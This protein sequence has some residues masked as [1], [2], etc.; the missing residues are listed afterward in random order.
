MWKPRRAGSFAL[1]ALSQ[2]AS[3]TTTGRAERHLSPHTHSVLDTFPCAQLFYT[4]P[5]SLILVICTP[6]VGMWVYNL[7]KWSTAKCS[8]IK[9]WRPFPSSWEFIL[10]YFFK[11]TPD[12]KGFGSWPELSHQITQQCTNCLS[13]FWSSS[14]LGDWKRDIKEEEVKNRVESARTYLL[15]LPHTLATINVSKVA[16]LGLKCFTQEYMHSSRVFK[17]AAMLSKAKDRK[18]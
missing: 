5:I 18:L 7:S 6:T 13:G 16:N 9:N 4:W 3:R 11:F 2:S 17:D 15:H 10:F 8:L 14:H 12:Y 1:A